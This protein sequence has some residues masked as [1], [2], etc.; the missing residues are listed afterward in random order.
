[1]TE[2]FKSI[3]G[4]LLDEIHNPT[5]ILTNLPWTV[6]DLV[7]RY[8]QTIVVTTCPEN[9]DEFH[10]RIVPVRPGTAAAELRDVGFEEFSLVLDRTGEL[11]DAAPMIKPGGAFLRFGRG[12]APEGFPDEHRT[13][14]DMSFVRGD[15]EDVLAVYVRHP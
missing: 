4:V 6:R 3:L 1:M 7:D 5:D 14:L 2:M 8:P 12:K 9:D 11:V 15:P 10:E 13:V